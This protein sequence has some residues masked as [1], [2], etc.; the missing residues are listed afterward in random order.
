VSAAPARFG[1]DHRGGVLYSPSSFIT[2]NSVKH[3]IEDQIGRRVRRLRQSRGLSLGDVATKAGLSRSLLSKVENARVSSPIATLVN[4]A[5]ALDTTVG[6]LIGAD[7]SERCVVVRRDERKLVT[8]KQATDGYTYE[9]LGHKRLDK[10]MEPFLVTYPVGAAVPPRYSH[11]GEAF[12]F[13]LK[14]RIE[15]HYDGQAMVLRQG[16]SVYFDNE[17][18]H[19]A[20]ATGAGPAVA[21]VVTLEP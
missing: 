13:V 7:N 8:A 19:G 3:D 9:T 12:M 20:R 16:D 5:T 2:G 18:P 11:R 1:L 17:L 21:L 14:G 6:H 10:R 15:F 4:I